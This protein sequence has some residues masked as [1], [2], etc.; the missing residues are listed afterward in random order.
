M[1][2]LSKYYCVF[3]FTLIFLTICL[4]LSS[5]GQTD[6]Q[7]RIFDPKFNTEK[8]GYLI[9]RRNTTDALVSFMYGTTAPVG[10]FHL[11]TD[12]IDKFIGFFKQKYSVNEQVIIG[13]AGKVDRNSYGIY[14]LSNSAF[15][16]FQGKV[17]IKRT[18]PEYDLDVNGTMRTNSLIISDGASE[19]FFLR[20]DALGN[21][22][23]TDLSTLHDDDWISIQSSGGKSSCYNIYL[24]EKYQYAGIGTRNPQSKLHIVDGNIMIS[25]SVSDAPG[26]RNGS[27]L[28]GA[29]IDSACPLGEWG[30]EYFDND[31]NYNYG[32]LNFWKVYTSYNAGFDH[33]LFIRNDGNV[34]IGTSTPQSKLAVNGTITAKE[35]EVTL[36]GFPDYVFKSDYK[37]PSLKEIEDFIQ[38]NGH[39]PEIPSEQE[40][41][42]NGLNVGEMNVILLKKVEELT[43]YVISL[44]KEVEELKNG[45]NQN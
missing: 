1:K 24:N 14:Q 5:F 11:E 40:V 20:S 9:E 16:Y 26:S 10:L 41:V 21:G 8:N 34:G 6:Y 31:T 3:T 25:R 17:G 45:S 38:I 12:N 44:Q 36:N 33:S 37:L 4:N 29:A 13:I 18:D 7:F 42:K 39:L 15:N 43:L 28:F 22:I 35:I 19:N 27:I 2:K 30:I 23:W 32:G